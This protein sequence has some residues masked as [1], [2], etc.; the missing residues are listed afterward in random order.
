MPNAFSIDVEDGISIAMRDQFGT[1]V[2][3]TNRVVVQTQKILELL[4]ASSTKATFFILG[5]VAESFPE[6][7]REI[8]RDGH[9]IGVHGYSHVVFSQMN[10]DQARNEVMSAKQLLE[11]ITGNAVIGHRAPCFS[12]SESTAWALDVLLEAGY[13]YD[14]SIMPC[15]G[16]GYGW[17]GQS[18]EIG[19]INTPKG[20]SIIEVPLTVATV[21]G[22]KI[23]ALGGSY[24]R[25][26]PYRYSKGILENIEKVRPAIVYLHPYELD[27]ERYP[28]YYFEQLK[29]S[30]L[31]TQIRMR[32]FWIRRGSLADRYARL[33]AEHS[34]CPIRE[35]V[36]NWEA[37]ST[38]N[39]D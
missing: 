8:A 14:S 16:I 39:I 17:P 26:L 5:A 23:P 34:F 36:S 11:E 37:T 12:V 13:H 33:L 30:S 19:R 35:L 15:S 32:S 9:E 4:A 29:K 28:D 7:V 10:P 18:L 25:L 38:T 6:L 2:P 31:L 21:L 24:S 22:K 27:C 20:Q 3:Q 1:R